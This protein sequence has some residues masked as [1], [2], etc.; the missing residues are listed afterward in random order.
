[1][2]DSEVY[3]K[4]AKRAIN[5]ID[6]YDECILHVGADRHLKDFE[7]LYPGAH[8]EDACHRTMALLF[9]ASIAKSEGR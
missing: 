5:G 1:M 2:K 9:M 6:T 8:F 3:L 7:R 4:A